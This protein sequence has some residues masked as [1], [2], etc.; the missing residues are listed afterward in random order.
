MQ[1][2]P[3]ESIIFDMDGTILDSS[4][5]MTNSVNH[6]RGLLGLEPIQKEFL[7]YHI[8]APDQNMP[9]IFYGT[10]EYQEEHRNAF[11]E[12]YLANANTHV[13]PYPGA[14]ELLKALHVRDIHLSVATNA[15]DFF[16]Y[17]MLEA[18]DMLKYF[19]YIV[20]ANNVEKSK[21]D[22][23]MIEYIINKS[24]AP[25]ERTLLVGD[26]IKDEL[27]AKNAGVRFVFASWG[28]GELQ[29]KSSMMCEDLTGLQKH[30]EKFLN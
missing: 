8:N 23:H 29:D 14:I 9:F 17:N 27:A 13:K 24:R 16:A 15:S 30:L 12:H 5:A 18:Q 10:H 1:D 19:R 25:K 7:E 4:F 26:S 6:V 22:P 21:P 2:T 3:I 20:G 11:K 28:Y